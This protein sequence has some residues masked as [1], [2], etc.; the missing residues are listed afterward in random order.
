MATNLVKAGNS[1]VV[2]D[3]NQ[4][5]VSKLEQAG[6]TSALSPAAVAEQ[7]STIITMLPSSPH[8]HKVYCQD[9]G[10]LSAVSKGSLLIDCRL[11]WLFLLFFS[12]HPW[13]L[14]PRMDTA[15]P[16]LLPKTY[17]DSS[18]P[19]AAPSTRKCLRRSARGQPVK[20][21]CL[22]TLLS[23]AVQSEQKKR[24]SRLWSAAKMATLKGSRWDACMLHRAPETLVAKTCSPSLKAPLLTA[25]PPSPHFSQSVLA[26]AMGQN[27]V[28]CG[29]V[30]MGQ[31]AKLCNNLILGITMAGV[32]E[33][34]QLGKALGIDPKMLAHVVNASSGRCLQDLPPP[35]M[36]GPSRRHPSSTFYPCC[37]ALPA[38]PRA[39]GIAS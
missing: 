10:I 6:A 24:H 26:P 2:Y 19:H 35:P 17:S 29:A 3:L 28:H 5:N 9:K 36:F 37:F 25:F 38:W 8:V 27:V 12:A 30:S 4:Y 16:V 20:V 39:L 22:P 18:C 7:A 23:V 13:R 34:F 21:R 14:C 11:V 33:A 32:S 1:V 31:V 15:E